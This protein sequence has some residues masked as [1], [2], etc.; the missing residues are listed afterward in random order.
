MNHPSYLQVLRADNAS[1]MTLDGTRTFVV[2]RD[3]P[4]V[5]D[6]GPDH[7]AH[8][9][10]VVAALGGARPAAILLTHA[11]P[12]HAA[13]APILAMRTGAPVRMAR[14]A[15]HPVPPPGEAVHW[16]ADGEVV[17]T[18]AGPLRAVATPGHAPEHLV[19]V[20]TGAPAPA[21]GAVFVGDLLMGEGDTT[22]VAPPE[23]DLAAYLASLDR[24]G[25]LRPDVLYPAH[26]PPLRDPEE[27]VARYRAH[28]EARLEQVRQALRAHPGGDADA[29]VDAVYGAELHPALR[30][31][32]RGSIQAMLHLLRQDD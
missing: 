6:P 22:L 30:R 5:I 10:A 11:H 31:A 29:L 15:L 17:K 1:P 13:A 12:D 23:G 4:V 27:A 25:R 18:D 9:D 14:G 24:V 2:G 20:W 16:L 19:F 26:G 28:R 3:R 32:A 8:L 7:P 21:G